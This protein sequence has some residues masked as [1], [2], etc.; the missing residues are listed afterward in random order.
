MS[1]M[2]YIPKKCLQW[3]AKPAPQQLWNR[4]TL[5]PTVISLTPYFVMGPAGARHISDKLR[6]LGNLPLQRVLYKNFRLQ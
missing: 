3:C 1:T 2:P 4:N 5:S 6:E